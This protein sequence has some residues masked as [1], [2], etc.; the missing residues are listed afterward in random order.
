[1]KNILSR[2]TGTLT[3]RF[4]SWFL[5]VSV[6]PAV[7]I[8]YLSYQNAS[9]AL[10]DRAL[11]R[12]QGISE[13]KEV[14]IA[15]HLD[16][17]KDVIRAF[18]ANDAF[19]TCTDVTM[20]QNDIDDTLK[21]FPQ[22]QSI[23]VMDTKGKVFAATDKKEIGEDKSQDP[24]FTEAKKTGKPYIKDVY[25]S[26]VTNQIGY[27]VS[28][29]VACGGVLAAR[30]RLDELSAV[31]NDVTGLGDT[32]EAYLVNSKGIVITTTKNIT[33]KDLL[34]KK[35]DTEG[36]KKC[37]AGNDVIGTFVDYRGTQVVGNYLSTE[38]TKDIG[39]NWCLITETD[40]S[41]VVA[42]AI[43]LRNTLYI[44]VVIAI[45]IILALAW[46]AS[47]S[48]GEFVRGPIRAAVE[49]LS[50]AATALAA[51]TQQ[52]AAAAQQN[53]AIAQQLATGSTDQSKR[54]EEVAKGVRDIN[55]VIQQMSA[56]SQEA[57]ASGHQSS[58]MA[59]QTGENSEKIGK[60]VEAIT[61]IS[62]QTNM[63][64]LNAAIEA[65]RAGEAGRGFAVVADEVR[66]LSENS[67]Q[68][69]EKIK[70]VV[71]DA[72]NNIGETVKG[73]QDFSKKVEAL[74]AAIQQQSSSVSQIA[75]TMEAIAA[76]AQQNA[77][78]AQ[79]LS[80]SVQQQSASNQQISAAVQQMNAM[81]EQL[82]KLA[83]EKKEAGTMVHIP[84]QHHTEST[85]HTFAKTTHKEK[86]DE[87]TVTK[88]PMKVVPKRTNNSSSDNA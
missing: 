8:T 26:S 50:A 51:S 58:K 56:S 25:V 63:L 79:Q 9:S 22:F 48:V 57:A 68:S 6:I 77:S 71:S 17:R 83:G 39:Q 21:I 54:A 20:I 4:V 84:E 24:F 69:A 62:E 29:P 1:M 72:V 53:S 60:L 45:G 13:V 15:E 19:V 87:S 47:R 64:A 66:K 46:Y 78:G 34:T 27:G 10:M 76:I 36:V 32:G 28:T 49:Q 85:H 37:L 55:A 81:T 67:G 61:V 12:I 18:G 75:K 74:S 88:P 43:A 11:L 65:A 80:A 2:I 41:E 82:A 33:D 14:L 38:L 73:I 42:P 23:I 40:L 59:Q 52:S 16:A 7:A 44:I 31:T 70:T 35:I 30:I 3:G 5:L 86:T